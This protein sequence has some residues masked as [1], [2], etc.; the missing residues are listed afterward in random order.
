MSNRGRT[1]NAERVKAMQG[2]RPTH[3]ACATSPLPSRNALTL[4]ELLVAITILATLAALFL[5]VSNSA[6]ESARQARTKTTIAKLHSLLMERWDEYTTRRVDLNPTIES[7]I[8]THFSGNPSAMGQ[9]LADARLLALRELM[10]LEMPD[11]WSDIDLAQ[12]PVFTNSP[13]VFVRDIPAISKAYYRKLQKVD[14]KNDGDTVLLER[15]GSAE[16]LYMVIMLF[17]GDGE[18]RTLFSRQDI[19][20]TDEDGA[21]E[22]IDGWGR[23][24]RWIRWP[25]GFVS[26]SAL[27]T[28]S[29]DNPDTSNP[30]TDYDPFDPFRRNS[31][32]ALPLASD[33]NG[34]LSVMR[35]FV[36]HLRGTSLDSPPTD[37]SDPLEHF[38]IGYRLTPLIFSSGPDGVGD[39][40]TDIGSVVSS[41]NKILLDPYAWNTNNPQAY[42]LGSSDIG[43]GETIND[44]ESLDNIHNHLQDGS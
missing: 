22:F 26:E 19:G 24:I 39:M 20:D 30:E 27:M 38:E 12:E 13:L 25:A 3:H 15:N 42:R 40:T 4:I 7:E 32:D 36:E 8:R 31:R 35:P 5:G 23:P 37:N 41:S 1:R 28:S 18:A 44:D 11:R 21:P 2:H 29:P 10:K 43:A 17:T 34:N 14:S 6:M 16:C 33:F 9:A